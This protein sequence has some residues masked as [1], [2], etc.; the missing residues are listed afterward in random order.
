MT[1]LNVF[2]L[3]LFRNLLT[4]G[5]NSCFSKVFA[6]VLYCILGI[7]IKHKWISLRYL[8]FMLASILYMK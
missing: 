7:V 2:H 1:I 5:N 3:K 4:M 8:I 6:V